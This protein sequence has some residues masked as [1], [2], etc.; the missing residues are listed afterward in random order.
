MWITFCLCCVTLLALL[1]VPGAF[2]A[3]V[4]GFRAAETVAVAPLISIALFAV[5]GVVLDLL[6]LKGTQ[7]V[8]IASLLC[9]VTFAAVFFARKLRQKEPP[10]QMG[11]S[12][13]YVAELSI[14]VCVCCIA[15]AVLFL[16]NIDGADSFLECS[17]NVF[18]LNVIQSMLDGASLSVLH[19]TQY[20]AM[21]ASQSPFSPSGG[22]YPAGWHILVS[23]ACSA[24]GTVPAIGENAGAFVFAGVVFPL[25]MA[26][27]LKTV[28][29][30]KKGVAAVGSLAFCACAAFPLAP[31]D[32]HQ[33]YPNFAALCCLP[34]LVAFFVARMDKSKKAVDLLKL[35]GLLI[36]PALGCAILHPNAVIAFAMMAVA[37]LVFYPWANLTEGGSLPTAARVGIPLGIVVVFICVW[38][39]LMDTPLFSGVT[40][41]L[42]SWTTAPGNAL[43]LTL[44]FGFVLA[45]PQVV[46]AFFVVLGFVLCLLKRETRWLCLALAVFLVVFFFNACGDPVLK[47]LFAGYF[48]TDAERTAALAAIAG[49]PCASF[50]LYSA[51]AFL[52]ERSAVLLADRAPSFVGA[53]VVPGVA[54]LAFCYAAYTPYFP[55][56]EDKTALGYRSHELRENSIVAYRKAFTNEEK[57]FCNKA[58][59]ITGPDALVLNKPQDGSVF[60]Y[61][62]CGLNVY[63]KNYWASGDTE[64]SRLI[65]AG[66]SSIGTD[67]AVKNAVVETGAKY[68]IVL[69]RGDEKKVS[70]TGAITDETGWDGFKGLED[71]NSFKLVLEDG[72]RKLYE[73]VFD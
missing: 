14:A 5:L 9:A 12:W 33:V 59:E 55:F 20:A 50:G 15:M 69:D 47:K 7:P 54:L 35:V 37:F 39:G 46:F 65:Q 57:L 34:G 48:Y 13:P 62:I 61:A 58:K 1:Y 23:M 29:P 6:G 11:I 30:C 40:S 45:I 49:I 4:A 10:S 16:R 19:I 71:N 28:F 21:D 26:V 52:R 60:S 31:L 24:V 32:V 36:V 67:A 70:A 17:D 8:L 68:V 2:A 56:S 41:Y 44:S 64:N 27:L 38:L 22:F 3:K 73:I 25:G 63:F 18:H 72:T 42:W 53:Y 66:L 43:F 51:V